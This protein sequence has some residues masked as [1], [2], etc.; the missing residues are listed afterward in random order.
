MQTE[1]IPL[2]AF[3][4]ETDGQGR[5]RFNLTLRQVA[6]HPANEPVYLV[7]RRSLSRVKLSDFMSLAD[8]TLS[9][10]G[11]S[12]NDAFIVYPKSSKSKI[13]STRT[14]ERQKLFLEGFIP[15]S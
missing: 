2:I 5:L 12:M 14:L 11:R 4:G 8:Q 13:R 1:N 15:H 9:N 3:T 6:G 7:S 10:N